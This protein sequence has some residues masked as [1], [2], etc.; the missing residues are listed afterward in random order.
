MSKEN[1]VKAVT[2]VI[3]I[4]VLALI[5]VLNP[6]FYGEFWHV[7]TSGNMQETVDYIDSFGAWAMVFSFLL[8]TES[9]LRVSC[10]NY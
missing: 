4:A 3:F 1:S 7:A 9:F 10:G 8:P 6:D 2:L 5:H